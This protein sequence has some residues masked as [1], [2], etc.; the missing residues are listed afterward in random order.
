MP[1]GFLSSFLVSVVAV[2]ILSLPLAYFITEIRPERTLVYLSSALT[3]AI[4]FYGNLLLQPGLR[5]DD[6]ITVLIGV[7][8]IFVGLPIATFVLVRIKQKKRV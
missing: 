5:A 7:L 2:P 4:V 1:S 8:P 3:P 6:K